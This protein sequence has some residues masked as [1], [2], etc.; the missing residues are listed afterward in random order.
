MLEVTII[1]FFQLA[2]V[3]S[4]HFYIR[5]CLME[6]VYLLLHYCICFWGRTAKSSIMQSGVRT[7]TT[8]FEVNKKEKSA[9][10]IR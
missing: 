5:A 10:T 3:E 4:R 1:C 2:A 7:Q 9:F 6:L 8:K